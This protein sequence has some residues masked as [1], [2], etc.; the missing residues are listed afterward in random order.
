MA[1]IEIHCAM[2]FP[3]KFLSTLCIFQHIHDKV[4]GNELKNKQTN[5]QTEGFKKQ[6]RK[7]ADICSSGINK[8]QLI[9]SGWNPGLLSPV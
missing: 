4:L 3:Y 2:A 8:T 1:T 5:K 7:Q 9:N 6:Q